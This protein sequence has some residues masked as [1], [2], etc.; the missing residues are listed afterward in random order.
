MAS[1]HRPEHNAVITWG[2]PA[3]VVMSFCWSVG[4]PTTDL[5]WVCRERSSIASSS[6]LGVL[7]FGCGARRV[8]RRR[9]PQR[10]APRRAWRPGG[11]RVSR[12]R[13]QRVVM[14]SGTESWTVIGPDRAPVGPLELRDPAG[15]RVSVTAHQ[16][17]HTLATRMINDGVP[18]EAIRRYLD[19]NSETMTLRYARLHDAELRRH[20]ERWQQRRVNI[21]GEVLPAEHEHLH[22]ASGRRRRWPAPA[23]PSPTATAGFPC[24]RPVP[25]PTPASAAASSPTEATSTPIAPTSTASSA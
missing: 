20:W 6:R 23:R 2:R 1:P 5:P 24:S 7:V 11:V 19:H 8:G 3:R 17:R 15:R 14:P 9:R 22:D 25:T 18:L 12:L 13:V 16:F 10:R 4:R 21:H